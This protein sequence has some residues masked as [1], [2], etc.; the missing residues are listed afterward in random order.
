MT[1]VHICYFCLRFK[2]PA[3][4]SWRGGSSLGPLLFTPAGSGGT[5]AGTPG[6]G[7]STRPLQACNP[8][9]FGSSRLLPSFLAAG[10][11]SHKLVKKNLKH[12]H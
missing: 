4:G 12:V 8:M 5:G 7:V 1:C 6:C 3:Q 10:A 11:L 9:A 2:K